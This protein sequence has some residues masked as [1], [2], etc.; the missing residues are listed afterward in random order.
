MKLTE[1]F[2]AISVGGS[3]VALLAL[4]GGVARADAVADFYK[5]RTVTL[6][7]ASSAGGGYGL[8]GQ[9][10]AAHFGRFLPGNPTTIP[11][12]MS[13]AG[14][15]KAANYVYNAAPKDGSAL[16]VLLS[17][18]PV[19]QYVQDK[20][21]KYDVNKFQWIGVVAPVVQAFTVMKTAPATTLEGLR[22]TEIVAGATGVGSD[23]YV[24]PTLANVM[25]GT[26]IKIVKGYKGTAAIAQAME[27][28]E[29][30]AWAGPWTS[31]AASFPRLLD[32][33]VA[34]QLFQFGLARQEGHKDV[35]LL[36]ELVQD[37]QKKK[38]VAF[39]SGP[40]A[41]GRSL[42]APPGVPANRL[43]ALRTAFDRMVKDPAFLADA[44]R[45]KA[46]VTPM[47]GKDLQALIRE[48]TDVP[49][50]VIAEAKAILT[51][52]K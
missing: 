7:V 51:V 52:E 34:V 20:A 9:L 40:T 11:S 15:L 28:G 25:L 49:P 18:V 33:K 45:R 39:L 27:Q 16:G 41:L 31:K 3:A 12:Y 44:K 50:S 13:G 21:A 17:P 29:A 2:R 10:M 48:I 1:A 5:G 32:P 36:T 26:K 38:V 30:H 37:P 14:G 23:T 4:G 42:V 47:S 35:P 22:K 6:Y 46:D 8:Y 19:Q 24:V 43:A